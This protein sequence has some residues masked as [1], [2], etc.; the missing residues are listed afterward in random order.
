MALTRLRT[1]PLCPLLL[2]SSSIL[3][4]N[5]WIIHSY[6]SRK[7][8]WGFIIT[9][10]I[11]FYAHLLSSGVTI[12]EYVSPK[13]CLCI[14]SCIKTVMHNFNSCSWASGL[15]HV[16]SRIHLI[17]N[18][19]APCELRIGQTNRCHQILQKKDKKFNNVLLSL[20]ENIAL[21]QSPCRHCCCRYHH[22]RHR[23]RYY[24]QH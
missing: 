12:D 16:W 10:I 7:F 4:L 13:Q 22:Y 15:K 24:L 14:V 6:A 9:I 21:V 5:G 17:A 23:Q 18:Q 3:P 11:I 19:K 20:S 1:E 8:L 2:F